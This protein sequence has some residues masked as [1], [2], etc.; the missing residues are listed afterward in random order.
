MKGLKRR[1]Q[2]AGEK[3]K[4]EPDTIKMGPHVSMLSERQTE[5]TVVTN[6]AKDEEKA[7]ADEGSA[8]PCI[9]TA[10]VTPAVGS[11]NTCPTSPDTELKPGESSVNLQINEEILK[12][13]KAAVDERRLALAS[14]G[15]CGEKTVRPSFK[16]WAE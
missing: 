6:E 7:T 2:E 3:L 9:S 8:G 1:L 14:R 11:G 10:E 16:G 15:Q 12:A 5:S 13:L 4:L